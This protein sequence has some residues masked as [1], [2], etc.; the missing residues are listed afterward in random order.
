MLLLGDAGVVI[1]SILLAA[2]IRLAPHQIDWFTYVLQHRIAFSVATVLF[3]V[4]MYASGMY[5]PISMVRKAPLWFLP[6]V[7]TCAGMAILIIVFFAWP[8]FQVG[9]GVLILSGVFVC[10]GTWGMRLVYRMA[11]GMGFLSRNALVVGEPREAM[12]VVRLIR[13]GMD[14][15]YRVYGVV[16]HDLSPHGTFVEGVP[17]LGHIAHLREFVDAYEVET[18]IVATPLAV[19]PM[20]LQQ[21]RP[22]RYAGIEL[23]DYTWLYEELAQEIPLDHIDDEWLMHAAMNSSVIHIRKIKRIMDVAVAIVGL[24]LSA[25]LA[26]FATIAIRLDSPGP[27]LY[28][29]RRSGMDGE[30]YILLKFRT[31]K[32]DAEAGSGAVWAGKIDHRVTR[33]GAFLRKWR[34]DEIPQLLNVLK[35]EMSLVGPRPERPE[36]VETLAE[37]IPFYRERLMVPPGITGWA[38]V[39]YPYAASM[40]ASRR[41]L[42]FDLY[43][44]KHM[45]FLL[46]V[47]ILLR[48]FRT[49]LVGLRHSE[50][51]E[52]SSAKQERYELR[53]LE[54]PG[55]K[56]DGTVGP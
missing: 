18:V 27:I 32:Q 46:D 34:V 30:P 9:R 41:K 33:V 5:E 36:F 51:V 13:R 1:L 11:A 35:G 50:E 38:Q 4:V 49:I 22:L 6:L 12:E 54:E 37:N 44:I 42:Q 25:P 45:R 31:M 7:A 24:V 29:Q 43:Y 48:T 53:V 52:T 21:L 17:V 39:K 8:D 23:M 28:R 40:E 3:L 14:S 15:G 10:A 55:A 2:F 47:Q 16:T 20:L 19:E 56:R 26:L